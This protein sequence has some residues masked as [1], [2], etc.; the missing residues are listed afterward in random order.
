MNKL[1]T[2]KA[3]AASIAFFAFSGNGFAQAPV[4]LESALGNAPGIQNEAQGA[5]AF[6]AVREIGLTYGMRGGMAW[7]NRRIGEILEKHA[8]RLDQIYNFQPLMLKESVVP[9][10]MVQTTET[11]DQK[12]P[13][14]VV[15]ADIVYRIERPERFR[16]T[17]PNWREYLLRSDQFNP[18]ETGGWV[19]RNED[20]RKAWEKAVREGWQLGMDQA[21]QMLEANFSRLSRDLEGMILYRKLLARNMTSMPVISSSELGVTGNGREM[22]INERVLRIEVPSIMNPD[23]YTWRTSETPRDR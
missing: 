1:F 5:F 16:Y 2:F 11:Y 4:S 23:P 6:D 9:P 13:D 8:A 7:E 10:V 22:N 3:L 15:V 14:H 18:S 17:P 19:P 12:N 21:H 20:E